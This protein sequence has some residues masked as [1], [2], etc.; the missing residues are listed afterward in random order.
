[1]ISLLQNLGYTIISLIFIKLF[2]KWYFGYM[3]KSLSNKYYFDIDIHNNQKGHIHIIKFVGDIR[4]RIN[5][6]NGDYK[7]FEIYRSNL[8]IPFYWIIFKHIFINNTIECL[9]TKVSKKIIYTNNQ[10]SVS[11][12]FYKIISD[13]IQTL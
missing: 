8:P 6:V 12:K 5:F 2:N 10:V 9:N 11:D 13:E 1:M 4:L 3:D 7:I